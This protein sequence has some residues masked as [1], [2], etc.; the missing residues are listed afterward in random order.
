MGI[1]VAYGK[2]ENIQNA[3]MVGTIPK[4]SI[5]F[6]SDHEDTTEI[7]FYDAQGSLKS[8]T[9][10][11]TGT[12]EL[13]ALAEKVAANAVAIEEETA[14]RTDADANIMSLIGQLASNHTDAVEELRAAD[15]A[16]KAEFDESINETRVTLQ[17]LIEQ[18]G[19][20][21][22][23][24]SE[25]VETVDSGVAA[26]NERIDSVEEVV[27][28]LGTRVKSLED[29][30]GTSGEV[31]E[32]VNTLE[33]DVAALEENK[34]D[35]N[36][37][38]EVDTGQ[39]D[40]VFNEVFGFGS[41]SMTGDNVTVVGSEATIE[42]PSIALQTNPYGEEAYW[43]PGLRVDAP[44]DRS[45]NAVYQTMNEATGEWSEVKLFN[46]YRDGDDYIWLYARAAPEKLTFDQRWQFDWDADG[47]Y[48]QL[49]TI[50]VVNAQLI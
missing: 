21:V 33:A 14:Q 50:K 17:G 35:K 22:N 7:F 2:K 44:T 48:E 29:S 9:Q 49:V 31:I 26:V 37:V 11:G 20:R 24:V 32:R 5:I 36:E 15:A 13:K 27:D 46:D 40:D 1:R 25:R 34:L 30:G 19:L 3:I 41:L 18:M 4:D 42:S 16:L 6:T 45:E 47:V 10:S 23:E 12:A 8:A 38:A 43:L 39:V 28:G